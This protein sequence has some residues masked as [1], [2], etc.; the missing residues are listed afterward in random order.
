M[1]NMDRLAV[2]ALQNAGGN[3]PA[4]SDG[5]PTPP[6]GKITPRPPAGACGVT[7]LREQVQRP[8][9]RPPAIS[10]APLGP[11]RAASLFITPNHGTPSGQRA[12][13]SA[14]W[15]DPCRSCQ[16]SVEKGDAE[17]FCGGSS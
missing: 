7:L 11:Y 4:P 17:Q 5:H 16:H 6:H 8:V 9:Y 10:P 2:H 14:A 12:S 13:T 1:S 3:T 15:E